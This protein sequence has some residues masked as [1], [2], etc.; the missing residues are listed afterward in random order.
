MR[1]IN[2]GTRD[3]LRAY[4]PPG[5]CHGDDF[6]RAERRGPTHRRKPHRLLSV[7]Y[8][9]AGEVLYE[10]ERT[11]SWHTYFLYPLLVIFLFSFIRQKYPNLYAL[12]DK[13]TQFCNV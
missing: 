3:P 6:R 5:Q 7:R 10:E 2:N 8:G 9:D 12:F 11:T 4:E 1:R 13:I